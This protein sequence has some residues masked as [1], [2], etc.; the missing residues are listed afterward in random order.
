MA[1][2]LLTSQNEFDFSSGT[3][4]VTTDT[5]VEYCQKMNARLDSVKG[6]WRY[7]RQ[8]GLPYYESIFVKNPRLS[9]VQGIFR[10]AIMSVP[11]TTSVTFKNFAFSS[12]TRVLSFA[13]EVLVDFQTAPLN[14]NQSFDLYKDAT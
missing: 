13:F 11:G 9:D 1:T 2:F 7:A 3:F 4:A 8:N 5:A 12:T 14:F 10:R 6:E